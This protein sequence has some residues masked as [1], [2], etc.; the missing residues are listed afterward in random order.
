MK[1]NHQQLIRE[2][3][4]INEEIAAQEVKARLEAELKLNTDLI[5]TASCEL[6]EIKRQWDIDQKIFKTKL[7]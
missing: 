2:I 5:K 1:E 6:T 4:K 7:Y 3:S